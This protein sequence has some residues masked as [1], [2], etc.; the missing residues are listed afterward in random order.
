MLGK[1]FVNQVVRLA[2]DMEVTIV[3]DRRQETAAIGLAVQ[4]YCAKLEGDSGRGAAWLARLL[5]V[6]EVPGSNPGG[7]TKNPSNSR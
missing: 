6:Q 4:R 2:N 3:A 1:S 7:P 5:G